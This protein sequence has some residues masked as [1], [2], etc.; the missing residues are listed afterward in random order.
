MLKLPTQLE[1]E[2]GNPLKISGKSGTSRGWH[3]LPTLGGW[4]VK[5]KNMVITIFR[6]IRKI[7]KCKIFVI[8]HQI[9][10][11]KAFLIKIYPKIKEI[12]NSKF[13]CYCDLAGFAMEK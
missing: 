7:Q 10:S 9:Q 4:V 11:F 5:K 2:G 1:I 8:F 13:S 12:E 6:K 3:P